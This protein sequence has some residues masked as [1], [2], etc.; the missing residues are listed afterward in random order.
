MAAPKAPTASASAAAPGSANPNTP[1]A[2]G[3]PTAK[4]KR[5]P[6][7][8]VCHPLL[9][10]DADGKPTVKLDVWPADFSSVKHKA[11]RPQD[12]TS[13]AV[14]LNQQADQY[15]AKA[16]K[17][18]Q[19]AVDCATLGGTEDRKKVKKV[20]DIISQLG[21]LTK[22]LAGKNINVKDMIAGLTAM[23]EKQSGEAP[24]EEAKVSAA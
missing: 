13:E 18:R 2:T 6:I 3:E 16:K 22:D 17:L 4:Q 10:P 11:L 14:M 21:E 20:R 8:R 7:K 9:K 5:V 1:A 15:E 19:E 24:K 12:F 23:L